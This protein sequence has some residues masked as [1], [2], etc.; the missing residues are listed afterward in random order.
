[1]FLVQYSGRSS[2]FSKQASGGKGALGVTHMRKG[3]SGD[4]TQG[5]WSF[6][7]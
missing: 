4:N 3:A 5:E 2:N 6:R 7:G 1:M